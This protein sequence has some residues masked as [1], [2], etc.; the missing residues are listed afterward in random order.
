MIKDK[1]EKIEL[2]YRIIADSLYGIWL[3]DGMV[4]RNKQEIL[5]L[6]AVGKIYKDTD[7]GEIYY[8]VTL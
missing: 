1:I 6:E 3:H 2:V 7:N 5:Y 8:K 4:T